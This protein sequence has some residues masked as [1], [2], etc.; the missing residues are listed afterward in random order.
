MAKGRRSHMPKTFGPFRAGPPYARTAPPTRSFSAPCLPNKR[1]LLQLTAGHNL[2]HPQNLIQQTSPLLICQPANPLLP[3]HPIHLL[4]PKPLLT[5]PQPHYPISLTPLPSSLPSCHTVTYPT[6]VSPERGGRARGPPRGHVPFSLSEMSQ[7]EEKLGSF[8]ENPTR[9][10]KKFLRLSQA[11][12]LTW[13]DIYYILNATLT[14]DEKDCIWQQ[15]KPMLITY[16]TKTGI[17][18]LLM[19]RCLNYIPTGLTSPMT[20]VS[21]DSII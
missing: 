9:Y 20:Q 7:I 19:R 6:Y 15:Q 17:A 3:P 2:L 12:N 21:R 13:S 16:I 10:R 14:P 1:A 5:P 18:Q 11:Y 4:T 8:S